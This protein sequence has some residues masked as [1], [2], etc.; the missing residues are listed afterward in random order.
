MLDL[1]SHILNWCP[2]PFTIGWFT[3]I[4]WWLYNGLRF[5]QT[6]DTTPPA[7]TEQWLNS[8]MAA[9]FLAVAGLLVCLIAAS[10]NKWYKSGARDTAAKE[11]DEYTKNR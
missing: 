1:L 5:L 7:L 9:T 8:F 10:I 11:L 6:T 4:L 2:L 3:S